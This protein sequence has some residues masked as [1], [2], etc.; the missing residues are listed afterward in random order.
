MILVQ[1][2]N[3]LA[4]TFNN[5]VT[6]LVASAEEGLNTDQLGFN[7]HCAK[8]FA[9]QRDLN[10]LKN[11]WSEYSKLVQP[12]HIDNEKTL[13]KGVN[14]NELTSAHII[15]V[16]SMRPRNEERN[17]K[18]RIPYVITRDEAVEALKDI[19]THD[20]KNEQAAIITKI[21]DTPPLRSNQ[22][23]SST[24]MMKPADGGLRKFR[25]EYKL[26]KSNIP[27]DIFLMLMA[28]NQAPYVFLATLKVIGRET[29][30]VLD[31]SC[32]ITVRN[33]PKKA[34]C[35]HSEP[36]VSSIMRSGKLQPDLNPN[37]I[38]GAPKSNGG[39][40]EAS[41]LCDLPGI[42]LRWLPARH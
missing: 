22:P 32:K 36:S 12:F 33:Q 38:N 21:K 10:R 2:A 15:N 5:I 11:Q 1:N 25:G 16:G 28:L 19:K 34:R 13:N 42:Q 26:K 3:L 41:P 24:V 8:L 9:L 30:N 39:G 4:S 27:R 23:R 14:I 17:G 35:R 18:D 37:I 31:S 7:P 20:S 6:L 29:E 40:I